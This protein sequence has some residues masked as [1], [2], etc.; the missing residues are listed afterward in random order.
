MRTQEYKEKKKKE[1]LWKSVLSV[2]VTTDSETQ[3][4]RNLVSI[5]V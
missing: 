1:K 2:I 5:V 3:G 4:L